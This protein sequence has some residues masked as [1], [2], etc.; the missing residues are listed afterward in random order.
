MTEHSQSRRS[1]SADNMPSVSLSNPVL[2]HLSRSLRN[3][4]HDSTIQLLSG[5]LTI[6]S[7]QGHT[8]RIE[9]SVHAA[10]MHC[11][12]SR[13]PTRAT[14]RWW[15]NSALKMIRHLEDPVDD[16]FV[17]NVE[18]CDGNYR[19]FEGDWA[20]NSFYVQSVIDALSTAGAPP[21]CRDLLR[22]AK[23]LLKVS[24]YVAGRLQ[25]ARWHSE[26]SLQGGA[27]TMP[28]DGAIDRHRDAILLR[29]EELQ[30][31]DVDKSE[32]EPFVFRRVDRTRLSGETIGHTSLERRPLVAIQSGIVLA[33]P[34]AV[35]PAIR[36]FV[37]SKIP[38][39]YLDSFRRTFIRLQA[40]RVEKDCLNRL[41][42]AV[43]QR[44]IPSGPSNGL[45][46][47]EWMFKIDIDKYVHI[48]LLHDQVMD[49][50]NADGFR[51]FVQLPN[52]AQTH[53]EMHLDA[54]ADRCRE[55]REFAEGW[56]LV[57]LGG[58]G[59]GVSLRARK[60]RK[61]WHSSL[62]HLFDFV[63]LCAEPRQP[64]IRYLKF[65]AQKD[66]IQQRGISA[67]D[68]SGDY[69]TYCYWLDSGYRFAPKNVCLQSCPMLVVAGGFMLSVRKE[70]RRSLDPHGIEISP[71]LYVPAVRLTAESLFPYEQERPVYISPTHLELGTLAGAVETERGPR[72]LVA[73]SSND[74]DSQEHRFVYKFWEAFTNLYDR[75]VT[76]TE[77]SFQSTWRGPL[78]TVLDFGS[79]IF[80][81]NLE[82][83][84]GGGETGKIQMVLD[85]SEM[86]VTLQLPADILLQFHQ[87]ANSGE[88]TVLR[89][90][91]CGLL[92]L[93]KREEV[94]GEDDSMDRIVSSVLKSRAARVFHVFDVYSPLE[95]LLASSEMDP[96]F[97]APEEYGFCMTRLSYERLPSDASC[98]LQEKGECILF[99]NNMVRDI[100]IQ[101]R[102]LLRRLDRSS[103]IRQVLL[104][105]EAAIADRHHWHRCASAMVGLHSTF[106]DVY[107]IMRDRES[108]RSNIQLPS[109]T[110]LEMALCECAASGGNEA[111]RWTVD[112]LLAYARLLLGVATDSRSSSE[113]RLYNL[114]GF[115]R[116]HA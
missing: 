43:E 90:M 1:P 2:S 113:R 64:L 60:V 69:S 3:C 76:V 114:E 68:V 55:S 29:S 82:D 86:T 28:S 101:L 116:E 59:R 22:T 102:A 58:I 100:W 5:L 48:V 93:H 13:I 35:S 89:S 33:L 36:R 80:S 85:W 112:T 18:T 49:I 44:D 17:T 104:A 87:V 98:R 50:Q 96:T 21:V 54:V 12:G 71:G 8:L 42:G 56:T 45:P 83:L 84:H 23:A 97:I 38:R 32:L 62:L 63:M 34:A 27:V 31:I 19:V 74:G 61:S 77:I 16:V 4:D 67:T 6:P 26:E 99:L 70:S 24:D 41:Q 110:I 15:L 11:R 103:V 108:E 39:E 107:K 51:S 14:V 66:W 40:R 105:H 9:T 57:L 52:E 10:V 111:S 25:L 94:G 72:W 7:L 78:V 115:S 81:S 88:W 30:R 92:S 65:L 79:V 91:G 46:I 53:L 109:R 75:L 47:N 106:E 95:H 73:A 20:A 37:L